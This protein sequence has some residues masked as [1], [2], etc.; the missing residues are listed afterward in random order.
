MNELLTCTTITIARKHTNTQGS[1]LKSKAGNNCDSSNCLEQ[2]WVFTFSLL[3]SR[4][5]IQD[6]D[7]TH[8]WEQSMLKQGTPTESNDGF[9]DCFCFDWRTSHHKHAALLQTFTEVYKNV[10]FVDDLNQFPLSFLFA[11]HSVWKLA[12][13]TDIKVLL[14]NYK[15]LQLMKT[16]RGKLTWSYRSESPDQETLIFLLS[17]LHSYSKQLL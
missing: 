4:G 14:Q 11:T 5:S 9:S 12:V 10:V 6:D 8:L 3:F 16:L 13:K 2:H 17:C 1:F 15:H 7:C